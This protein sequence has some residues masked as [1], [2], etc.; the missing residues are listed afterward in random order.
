MTSSTRVAHSHHLVF[1]SKD[2]VDFLSK[3]LI[4]SPIKRWKIDQLLQHPFIS[5][6]SSSSSQHLIELGAEAKA[7]V[8]EEELD[9]EVLMTSLIKMLMI[10]S[11]IVG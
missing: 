2:F 11:L 9:D 4:K 6:C 8:F 7:E 1:R 3:C 5:S 10:S